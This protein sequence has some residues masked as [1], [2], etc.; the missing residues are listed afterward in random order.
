MPHDA[1]AWTLNATAV[2]VLFVDGGDEPMLIQS[3]PG[4]LG[5]RR[6]CGACQ[7]MLSG[8]DYP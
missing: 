3:S 4:M 1:T 7:P 6:R 2:Q 8:C 5:R